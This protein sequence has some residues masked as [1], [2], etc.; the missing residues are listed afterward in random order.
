MSV[1][2]EG[3]AAIELEQALDPAQPG[4]YAMP[5][6]REEG[7]LT[8]DWRPAV[9]QA[10]DD[11]L[12]GAA[13]G[14]VSARFH[15]GLLQALAAWANEAVRDTGLRQVVLGGG[16]FMNAQL[17]CGLP[18]LLKAQD[19]SVY[20]PAQVPAGDGGLSLGQAISAAWRFQRGERE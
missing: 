2:Y 20:T 18:P 13:P 11:V 9:G 16:C 3:Q 12:T 5:V 7:L 10:V 4:A 17:L 1:A 8:L 14:V 6:S 19:L 15:A